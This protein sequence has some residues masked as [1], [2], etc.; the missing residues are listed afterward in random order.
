M[1]CDYSATK[2]RYIL[3][4]LCSYGDISM[5]SRRKFPWNLNSGSA[6]VTV[7]SLLLSPQNCESY[8]PTNVR[9]TFDYLTILLRLSY[10]QNFH[11]LLVRN[12]KNRTISAA[13]AP[14]LCFFLSFFVS[15]DMS[16]AKILSGIQALMMKWRINNLYINFST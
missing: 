5:H 12:Q 2:N 14:F 4:V 10:E 9:E 8:Q 3:V 11:A 1:S 6:D 15:Y 16:G 7:T 13:S